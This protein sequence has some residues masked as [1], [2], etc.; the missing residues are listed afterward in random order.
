MSERL[1]VL[2]AILS[3]TLGGMAAAVT[4][5]VIGGIDP[6]T[7]A[8][9]RFG[10]GFVVLL[11]LALLLRSQWPKGRDLIFVALL[12][13]MFFAG[14]FVIY[15]T[16]LGYTT[17]ARGALALSTLPLLTMLAAAMLRAE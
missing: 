9:F 11:P 3:S 13:L 1:G 12:G 16:A 17:A 2:A 8:A 14:F 7:T 10:I 15:N 6:V 5:F 4:R